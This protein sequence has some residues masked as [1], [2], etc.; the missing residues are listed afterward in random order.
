MAAGFEH[1]L[2]IFEHQVLAFFRRQEMIDIGLD[3]R[4]FADDE[5]VGAEVENLRRHVVLNPGNKRHHRNHGSNANHH[6]EQSEHG[7]QLVGPQRTQ[8]DSDGFGDVHEVG[9][10]L[11][12]SGSGKR[13]CSVRIKFT[14]LTQGEMP[15]KRTNAIP[16]AEGRRRTVNAIELKAG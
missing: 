4:H 16:K 10:R 15:Q 1:G 14:S 3:R 11:S 9:F 2:V 5:H 6:A 12:A 8:R 13:R 7:A